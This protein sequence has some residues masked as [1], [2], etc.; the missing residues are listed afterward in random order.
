MPRASL[1]DLDPG[2]RDDTFANCRD[3]PVSIDGGAAH[4]VDDDEVFAEQAIQSLC[5]CFE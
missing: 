2:E 3:E 4:D 1:A 5:V